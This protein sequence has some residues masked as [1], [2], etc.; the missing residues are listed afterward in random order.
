MSAEPALAGE[1]V[2]V[3]KAFVAVTVARTAVPWVSEKGANCRTERGT[4]Q[5]TLEMIVA[6]VPSQLAVSSSKVPVLVSILMV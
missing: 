3:P 6:S 2:L 1:S 5:E 4:W